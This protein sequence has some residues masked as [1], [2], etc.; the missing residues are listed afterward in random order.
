MDLSLNFLLSYVYRYILSYSVE[1]DEISLAPCYR[2]IQEGIY[3]YV[4]KGRDRYI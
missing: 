2:I 4:S 3:L 1:A